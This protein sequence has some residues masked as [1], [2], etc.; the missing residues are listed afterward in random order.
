M[1]IQHFATAS[2]TIVFPRYYYGG[3]VFSSEQL[4]GLH[5]D[6]ASKRLVATFVNQT[7]DYNLAGVGITYVLMR[8]THVWRDGSTM[9]SLVSVPLYVRTETANIAI[10]HN[11]LGQVIRPNNAGDVI[12]SVMSTHFSGAMFFPIDGRWAPVLLTTPAGRTTLITSGGNVLWYEGAYL[13]GSTT[14]FC[15]TPHFIDNNLKVTKMPTGSTLFTMT[16]TSWTYPRSLIYIDSTHTAAICMQ[17]SGAT[18]DTSSPALVRLFNTAVDPWSLVWTDTLP[19]T[20]S[21]AAYD[22]EYEILYSCGKWP[23]NAVIHMSKL[24]PSPASLSVVTL[25]SGTTLQELQTTGMSV[26]VTDARNSGI[27]GVLT[28]WSLSAQAAS[29]AL[30]SAYAYTNVSGVASMTYIGPRIAANFTET[31]SV[32]VATIDPVRT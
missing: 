26:L 17:A 7:T 12:D 27:S 15:L 3:Q 16:G 5:W 30:I 24:K 9:D 11:D 28:H 29:G 32:T 1:T 2:S 6:A 8:H 13:K 23:S 4:R 19:A 20:D 18:M 21:V 10:L 31:V 14:A 22:P 25:I